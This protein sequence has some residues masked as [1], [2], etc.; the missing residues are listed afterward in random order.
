VRPRGNPFRVALTFDA[1]HPDR[2]S[3][4]AVEAQLLDELVR[5]GVRTTF[6]VQGRWAEAYP[7]LTRRIRDEGHLIGSHSHYHARMHLL[8]TRGLRADITAAE[9][10]ILDATGVD[11]KPWFRCPFGAGSTD[12]RVQSAV[13]AAGYRH[14]GWDVAGEDWPPERTAAQVETAVVDGAIG[15]GDI[16]VVLLHAWPDRTADALA[17]IVGRLGDAGATF[18]RL[19]ELASDAI[20]TLPAW[21]RESGETG[22]PPSA[23]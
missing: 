6:L 20:P 2:P 3:R 22:V 21:A 14:V 5:H 13:T 17:G 1:E 19:D 18:V 12:R 4:P 23:E 8:T 16:T 10:A 11:P 7:D 15:H 9:R